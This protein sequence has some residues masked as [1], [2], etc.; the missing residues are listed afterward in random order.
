MRIL[1][2][3]FLSILF[4]FSFILITHNLSFITREAF[5]EGEFETDYDVTYNINSQGLT[6]VTQQIE[7]KNKTPNFYAERFQLKIGSTK[8]DNV[9]ASDNTGPLE[10]EINFEN[11]LT[12]ISVKFNQKVI[13][14]GKSLPWQ[15]TYTS[16]ELVTKNGQIWEISIPRLARSA[17]I[18]S[19]RA[20]I[21]VP[22]KFGPQAFAIPN[23]KE[24]EK[25]STSQIFTFDKDQLLESGIAMSFGEKQVFSFK[26]NYYLDNNNVTSQIRTITLPPDNNY[27]QV[28]LEKLNPE[29]ENVIVDEDGNFKALYRLKP[30]QKL[31]AVAEGFVEVFHKPFRNIYKPLKNSDKNLYT[32]PQRYWETDNAFIKDKA[33]EL[34]EPQKIYDFVVNFLSY[35]QD[36]LQEPKIERKGAASA[37]AT[38]N[39]SI[40]MEFTDLFIAIARAAGIPT[41]EVTG[42]A[43]TQNERLRP[44]SLALDKGDILHAWPEYWDTK[45][46]WVQI[47]PTWG[48][49][50]GGLDF[51][52]KLDFNHITFTQRGK[53]STTP[54]PPGSFKRE[55]QENKKSVFVEFAQNLPET[56]LD[57][58]L[59]I[60]APPKIISGIPTKVRAQVKNQG[61]I[62]IYDQELTLE[63]SILKNTGQT[64]FPVRILPP[65]ST[66][67][68]DFRLTSDNLLLNSQDTLVLNYFDSQITQPVSIL[69]FYNLIFSPAFIA[70]VMVIFVLIATGL[71]LYKKFVKKSRPQIPFLKT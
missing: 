42:F 40:C 53:S 39:D 6:T 14:T 66:Q 69:P 21:I 30:R 2:R 25:S 17:D 59:S 49:T 16:S 29:P 12:T 28:V 8:V 50:S 44:L 34:K 18:G 47:D 26:L 65:F 3:G 23:P 11:N 60:V 5:A 58:K 62:S 15:L 7:L 35:S 36:R 71:F 4:F 27:Q 46:G 32:Q 57:S 9:S 33:S 51:F 55:D 1:A 67:Y 52:N 10:T 41:R 22:D 24:E 64:G 19:Y 43:Y 38:P 61:S 63:A 31:D 45:L 37:Y 13:G 48:S 68:F 54:L 56:T 20:R 70:S